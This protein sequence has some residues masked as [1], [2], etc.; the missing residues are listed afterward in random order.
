M[1]DAARQTSLDFRGKPTGR[2]GWRPGAGRPKGRKRPDHLP[3]A[4][5]AERYPVHVTQRL[6]EDVPS[7]RR[8][9]LVAIVRRAIR[10]AH[11]ETFRVVH[12]VVLSNHLHLIV[13]AAGAP[14]LGR[15][16]QGLAI[17]LARNLNRKLGRKGTFF[18]ERYHARVLT[19]PT[20]VRNTIRYVL[21]NAR[22][23]DAAARGSRYWYDPC[24]SAHWFDGWKTRLPTG[25]PW[26][27]ALSDERRPTAPA[28]TW[29]L[30]TGWRRWGPIGLDE[31]PA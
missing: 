14:A 12:F 3:R 17:R 7:I 26:M 20:Q 2:G 28:A 16:M 27:R 24:S 13:E 18:A 15:G 30:A 5:F 29:L 9:H 8:E 10:A 11:R 1:A 31:M 22:R 21:C 23:H 4:Q 25:E 19:N 6:R